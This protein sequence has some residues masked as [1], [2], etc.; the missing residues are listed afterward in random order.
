MK[1]TIVQG[2]FYPVPPLRGGAVERLWFDLGPSFVAAGHEVVHISRLCDALPADEVREGVRHVRLPGFDFVQN[3]LRMK[4]RDLRYSLRVLNSLPVSDIVVTHTFWLPLLLRHSRFGKV[5]VHVARFPKGQHKFYHA[6]RFQCVST[7]V[8]QALK[9]L[10]PNADAKKVKVIP[11]AVRLAQPQLDP[12]SPVVLL[13]AGRI[14]PEKGLHVLL[15][16]F[17]RIA[18][19]YP[20]VVLRVIGPVEESQGG[21]GPSY[22]AELQQLAPAGRVQW[23]PPTFDY[24]QLQEE[25]RRATLMVYPSLAEEGESFGLA[26][27]EAMSCGCPALVSSLECFDDYLEPGVNGWK[28]DHRVADPAQPLTDLLRKLLNHPSDL[29]QARKPAAKTASRFSV[30]AVAESFLQDFEE[31]MRKPE[32]SPV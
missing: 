24:V 31:L 25:Y 19:E 7:A 9:N 20:K 18:D 22:L 27:L 5:Y 4:W 16:A 12:P 2:A 30:Q 3:P 11:N 32:K 17:A 15:Q 23:C 8:A 26:P 1:I 29:A 6:D 21:A 28:F 10:L 14:H 13:Y